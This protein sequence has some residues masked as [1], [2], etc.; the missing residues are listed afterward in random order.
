MKGAVHSIESMGLVDGPGIRTVVFLQGCRLRCRFCHN[1]DTW[2]LSGGEEISPEA[3]MQKIRRFKPYFARSGGGVTFSG[4]EPLLQPE[5]LLAM[6]R[7][8]KQEGIH[9]CLDTA[10]AGLGDYTEIL[11]HTD[12]I[13]YDVKHVTES[14]YLDMTGRPMAET[15]AF[16]AEAQRLGVPLWIRHVLVPGFTDS[17]AHLAQLKRFVDSLQ[18]VQRVE[19]LPYHLLGVHKYE[20]MQLPY[21]LSGVPAMDQEKAAQLQEEF[22][23]QFPPT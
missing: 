22:F 10:G 9:T 2:Q 5:F 19:L 3:L 15:Q 7:L 17:R 16:L 20:T 4:G 8:L 11:R 6:L 1:P 23:P 13:L 14:G 18:H 12:L 21:S